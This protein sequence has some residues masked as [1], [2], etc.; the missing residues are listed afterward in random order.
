VGRL[1]LSDPV[2][3]GVGPGGHFTDAVFTPGAGI[4]YELE[5]YSYW[6]TFEIQTARFLRHSGERGS[7][8]TS[9][10]EP[11]AS[12]KWNWFAS[13]NFTCRSSQPAPRGIDSSQRDSIFGLLSREHSG[14]VEQASAGATAEKQYRKT[15]LSSYI[16]RYRR[17]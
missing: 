7:H 1:T 9:S 8:P 4:A 12:T 14:P 15:F 2:L 3:H 11:T 16:Q 10:L 5:G 13:A 6:G 17:D